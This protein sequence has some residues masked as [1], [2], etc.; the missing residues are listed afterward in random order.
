MTTLTPTEKKL[1]MAMLENPKFLFDLYSETGTS[2][3]RKREIVLGERAEDPVL[4]LAEPLAMS[5]VIL[6][7]LGPGLEGGP[8][9]EKQMQ[10]VILLSG[11]MEVEVAAGKVHFSSGSILLARD[12]DSRDGHFTRFPSHAL[13]FAAQVSVDADIDAWLE[14]YTRVVSE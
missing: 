11:E 14:T 13:I 6:K 10:F 12:T 2:K 9:P 8:H 3:I 7:R 5:S 1:G 4:A